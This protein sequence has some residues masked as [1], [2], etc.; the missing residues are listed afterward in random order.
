[1]QHKLTTVA[2]NANSMS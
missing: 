2:H 1:M